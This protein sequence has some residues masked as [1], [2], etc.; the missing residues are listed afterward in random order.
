MTVS[1]FKDYEALSEAS[2]DI[3]V[4]QLLRKP[5]SLFCFPSGDTPTGLLSILV[6]KV[7]SGEIDFSKSTFVGLD[8]W[9]GMDEH[10]P[11]SCKHYVYHHFFIPAGIRPEQITFFD[12]TSK[13]LPQECAKVDAFLEARGPIDIVVVG[14][15]LNGHIGLNEP[16][17]SPELP[18]H[19]V[20]L[21]ASTIQSAAKYFPATTPLTHGITLGLRH[22]RN[23]STILVMAC[24]EKKSEIMRKIVEGPVTPQVPGSI[25]QQQDNALIYLD[26]ACASKLSK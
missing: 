15:G 21:E 3:I 16:G 26:E 13:D 6:G 14:V 18:C 19:V 8:E 17:V 1:V 20:P 23:A 5:E 9:V 22:I 4:Q 12:A 7:K 11:G 2:A 10:V 24:G 25:M